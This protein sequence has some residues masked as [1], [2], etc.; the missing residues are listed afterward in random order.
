M[1]KKN[2]IIGLAFVAIA[3]IALLSRGGVQDQTTTKEDLAELADMETEC[4]VWENKINKQKDPCVTL[5]RYYL[6]EDSTLEQK[7]RA[8][9]LLK[10]SC[11]KAKEHAGY[12]S[13][14][15]CTLYAEQILWTPFIKDE[16]GRFVKRVIKEN[17]PEA[18]EY[19]LVP[20]LA[21]GASKNKK[22]CKEYLKFGKWEDIQNAK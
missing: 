15:G 5:A 4:K 21:D 10:S 19:L 17:I 1:K 9:E 13:T 20:C 2:I 16:Q 6:H 14:E 3:I 7:S 12:A 18:L 8:E 11:K 22:S